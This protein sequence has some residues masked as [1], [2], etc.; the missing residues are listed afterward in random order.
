[1]FLIN[2]QGKETIYEQ[3]KSQ[4]IKFI[5]AGALKP[6]DKLPSVRELASDLGINPNT[7]QKAYQ[8]LEQDG[9]IY[10]V[11]KKGS[12]VADTTAV[13]SNTD[14]VYFL[15]NK[16]KENGYRKETVLEAVEEVFGS[17]MMLEIKN[18]TKAFKDKSVLDD[19]S[20]NIDHGSIFGLVGVNGAGKSTLLR[21]IAGIYS[22]DDGLVL[23]EGLDT[24][25]DVEIRKRIFLV[26]DDPYYPYGSSIKSLKMFYKSFYDFDEE[27]YQKYLNLFKLSETDIISNFSKGMKRQALL[28]I[29]LA[30]KPELLLL[31]E[32]F[33][34][35]DPIVRV[36]I[37]NAL[38]DLI[39]DN[40]SLIIISSHNLKELEDICDSYGILENGHIETYGD[41]LESKAN[42]N[43]YQLAFK[44]E[45]DIEMFKGFDVLYKNMEGRIVT[46]VIKGN[47]EDVSKKLEALN[48]LIL[49]V[50]NVNFEELFIYEHT[51]AL[52]V[53]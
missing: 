1:M 4:I 46:L 21:S 24:Q 28:L 10:S 49:D 42:I 29:A 38:S 14:E 6:N 12:F 22:L 48:P 8:E 47:R 39:E 50:L 17:Q 51:G 44:E 30:C 11:F 19:V 3:I 36:H 37:K 40:N 45:V 2:L 52:N 26:S 31:D 25:I 53:K 33:D 18:V 7:V 27:I 32:A 13:N 9:Y 16:L 41:L 23:F 34:G 35:L 15:L 20:L 43:K 5:N